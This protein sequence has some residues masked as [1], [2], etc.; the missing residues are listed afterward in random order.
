LSSP[1][2]LIVAD[3]WGD[4]E[5]GQCNVPSPNAD[6]VAV[7]AGYYH[8]VGLRSDGTVVAWGR[9]D[10]NQCTVPAP[11]S[12]FVTVAASLFHSVGLKSDGTVVAWGENSSGQ[13]NVPAPNADFVAVAAG[14]SH[15]LGLKSNGTIVV[16]GNQAPQVPAPNID[17]VAIAAGSYHS[18][19]LKAN[20]TIVAWGANY[21]GQCDV[22]VPNDR[23]V[24]VAGGGDHSLGVKSDGTIMAW[25]RNDYG[26][27]NVPSPN[28][29]FVHVAG[30]GLHSLGLK[31][32]GTI[33][34]WGWNDY[35]QC[36]VL[37]PN[38]GF[39]AIVAEG[40]R[41]LALKGSPATCGVPAILSFDP[42]LVTWGNCSGGCAVS[43]SVSTGGDYSEV[44]K[45]TL[46]RNLPGQW[47]EQDSIVAPIPA[48]DWTLSCLF[49]EHYTDGPHTFRAV[50][51][52]QDGS[53]SYS[54]PVFVTAERGVPV[55]ISGFEAEHSEGG[56]CLRWRIAEGVGLQGFNI[57]RSLEEN[58]SF[59]RINEELIP[60]DEA[61]EYTDKDASAGNTYWYR[62]GAV[63]D[64]GE[65]MSQTVSIAL[66]AG[67]LTLHQNVPNPFNPSTTI[68][69]TLAER[70]EVTLAI[71]DVKGRLV[72]T[73]VDGMV[74]EGYQERIW[75]G[76]DA[77]GNP[78]GSG[79]YFYR[80]TAGDKTLTKK[81]VLLK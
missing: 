66:P 9:N 54:F 11:N 63:A 44:Q 26:Q 2:V 45:I 67:T 69:F 77:S 49:D 34:A 35:G 20:G 10:E 24:A 59:E 6:F 39:V 15:S 73:L 21:S 48:P 38:E 25:G 57:Y 33:A 55:L 27:C 64:D 47:V 43:F 70:A 19:G 65:W 60:F 8:N 81:M 16:W 1:G 31:S 12:D 72:N 61:N 53:K 75:D 32:D 74:G 79:V 56:V 14:E 68:S 50:F 62:L 3:H 58:G 5:Y 30:G 76:K 42:T 71:Y 52:C 80:L 78:V 46:E 13:C 36:D 28:S 18:L 37:A 51:H 41:S 7:A 23:F 40:N 22:P 29:D 17:F 4:N